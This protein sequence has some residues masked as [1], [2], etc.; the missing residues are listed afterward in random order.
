MGLLV[1]VLLFLVAMPTLLYL[2][3]RFVTNYVN[4]PAS[5]IGF[6]SSPRS[7]G[8]KRGVESISQESTNRDRP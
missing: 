3:A 5:S 4:K 2:M 6:P 8:D 1:I 7:A